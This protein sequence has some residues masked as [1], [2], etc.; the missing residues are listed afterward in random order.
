MLDLDVHD[1]AALA[2]LFGAIRHSDSVLAA[3]HIEAKSGSPSSIGCHTL[4]MIVVGTEA[5]A[6]RNPCAS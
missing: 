4:G 6:V 2:A 1:A 3:W 5:I